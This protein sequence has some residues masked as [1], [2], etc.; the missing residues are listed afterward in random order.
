MPSMWT[1]GALVWFASL[2]APAAD[3]GIAAVPLRV[4][5]ENGP[6]G[7]YDASRLK[8]DWGRIKWS[9]LSDRVNVVSVGATGQALDVFY[10]RGVHG[11][12]ASAA[13]FLVALPDADAYWL[14]YRVRFAADFDFRLGGKL[15][16]L[17][18]GK[19][20]TGGHRPTGDGW[21]SRYMWRR[22]GKLVVYLYHLDQPTDYGDDQPLNAAAPTG[23]WIRLTQ[24][25]RVN[26]PGRADGVLRV[27]IDGRPALAR[28]DLRYRTDPAAVVNRFYFSTFYGGSGDQW[29]PERDGHAQFDDFRVQT[30]PAGL[31]LEP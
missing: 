27:W 3:P 11:D 8:A 23:A 5:F 10:P 15:P 6:L 17:A 31:E 26:T 25:V 24:H 19:A 18:G 1:P 21:S 14:D 4:G 2:L 20:N 9:D 30:T 22:Q 13:Q 16:G 7:L 12:E 29:S 28:T